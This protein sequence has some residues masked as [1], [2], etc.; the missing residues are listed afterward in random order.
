MAA[1]LHQL[2]GII[3]SAIGGE[4]D[5]APGGEHD[6]Y[7]DASFYCPLQCLL[8]LGTQS[9][10][11]TDELDAVLG[12]VDGIHIEVAD[13]ILR[14]MR[15]TIDDAHRL[16][17]SRGGGI[18]FEILYQVVL[19]LLAVILLAVDMLSAY[20]VPHFEEDLLQGI[21]LAAVDAAVHIVPFAYHLRTFYI[22]VG[23]VHAAGI[24]YLSVDDYDF[25]VVAVENGMY[26]WEL[27]GLVFEDFDAVG[28]DFLEMPF[29]QRLVVG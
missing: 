17:I 24:G 21:H 2:V 20:L 12:I 26:P 27:Q 9:E 13:D 8:E 25:A 7:L 1:S 19:F 11:G 22:I 14:D 6:L 16:V 15:L 23:N 18:G 5:I 3:E 28:T 4:R 29:S 10:V